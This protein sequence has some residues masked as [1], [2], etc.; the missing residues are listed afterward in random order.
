M[1]G[2]ESGPSRCGTGMGMMLRVPAVRN[3]SVLLGAAM[4]G[5][6]GPIVSQLRRPEVLNQV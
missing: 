1:P 2:P 6:H 3:V 4:T 5:D